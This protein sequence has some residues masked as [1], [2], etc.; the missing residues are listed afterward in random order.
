MPLGRAVGRERVHHSQAAEQLSWPIGC[1]NI[2]V[3]SAS[4]N[5]IP[6]S[7]RCMD[8]LA[9]EVVCDQRVSFIHRID[10]TDAP[11]MLI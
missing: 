2:A 9:N 5:N 1:V 10:R 8:M 7:P 11:D 6:D 3:C 4:R